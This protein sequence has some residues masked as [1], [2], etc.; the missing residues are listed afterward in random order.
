MADEKNLPAE[1]PHPCQRFIEPCGS[2]EGTDYC[3][4][5]GCPRDQHLEQNDAE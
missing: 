5:C 4:Y 2:Q 1:R 3:W